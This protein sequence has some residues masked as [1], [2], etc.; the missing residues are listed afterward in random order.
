M[1]KRT[2]ISRIMRIQN[3][4]RIYEEHSRS[5]LSNREIWRRYIYPVYGCTETVMYTSLAD[6]EKPEYQITPEMQ[7]LIDYRGRGQR[8]DDHPRQLLL[9]LG[10]QKE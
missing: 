3:I 8:P 6:A 4:K 5:G 1:A 2:G 9:P 7:R 10:F